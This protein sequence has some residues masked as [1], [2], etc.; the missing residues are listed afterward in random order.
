MIAYRTGSNL[1]EIGDPW[2]KVKITVIENIF[3]N[4]ENNSLKFDFLIGLTMSIQTTED[5]LINQIDT[6]F[7]QLDMTHQPLL[8]YR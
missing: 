6:F 3:Q 7:V 4:N 1:N 2:S 5:F 8:I